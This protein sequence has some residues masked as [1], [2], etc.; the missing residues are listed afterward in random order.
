MNI[1]QILHIVVAV[2]TVLVGAFSVVFPKAAARFVGFGEAVSLRGLS[3]VR[4]VIGGAFVGAGLAP[5]IVGGGGFQ[6]LGIIYLAIAIVRS[7]SIASLERD[8]SPSN[9]ISVGSEWLFAAIL[10]LIA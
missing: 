3:E 5:F 10:L 4:A 2:I 7:I 9:L 1:G 8:I 6:A